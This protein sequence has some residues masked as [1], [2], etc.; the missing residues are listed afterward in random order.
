[1]NCLV[2]FEEIEEFDVVIESGEEEFT[3]PFEVIEK[4]HLVYEE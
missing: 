1:M 4:G 3:F 2:H